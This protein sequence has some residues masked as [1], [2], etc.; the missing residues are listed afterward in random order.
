[1]IAVAFLSGLGMIGLA[2]KA[3]SGGCYVVDLWRIR[4]EICARSNDPGDREKTT[5]TQ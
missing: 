1:M 2:T 3:G 4:L 5:E